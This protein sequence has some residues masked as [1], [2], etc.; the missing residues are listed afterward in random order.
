M[1]AGRLSERER[2]ANESA[3]GSDGASWSDMVARVMVVSLGVGR[4]EGG[5]AGGCEGGVR[6]WGCEGGVARLGRGFFKCASANGMCGSLLGW[7]LL[8]RGEAGEGEGEGAGGVVGRCL[9]GSGSWG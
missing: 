4:G 8:R 5:G 9:A 1:W 6:G 7:K 2:R 3:G